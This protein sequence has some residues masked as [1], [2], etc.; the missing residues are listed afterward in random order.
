MSSPADLR[1]TAG[2]LVAEAA[3]IAPLLDD[4]VRR[5]GPDVWAGPA[6]ERFD[7]ELH[8]RR[9]ELRG[10]VEELQAAADALQLRADRL[11]AELREAQR[12]ETERREARRRI[13]GGQLERSR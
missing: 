12:R 8:V 3:A 13:A 9:A 6:A 11:E 7:A 10:V 5:S 2:A 1:A 4:V